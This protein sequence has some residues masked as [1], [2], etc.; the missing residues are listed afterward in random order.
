M[1]DT[2]LGT[3]DREMNEIKEEENTLM[4]LILDK[5]CNQVSS[6]NRNSEILPKPQAERASPATPEIAQKSSES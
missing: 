1:S 3:E 5:R 4:K 6:H 2:I